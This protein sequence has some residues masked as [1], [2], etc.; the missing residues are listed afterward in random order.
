V[1]EAL[2][3]LP[4]GLLAAQ[5]REHLLVKISELKAAKTN[6]QK[7]QEYVLLKA[8]SVRC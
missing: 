7:T 4:V 2:L 8:K 6:L 3:S 1:I 5:C